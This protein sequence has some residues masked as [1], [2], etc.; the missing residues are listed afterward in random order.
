MAWRRVGQSRSGPTVTTMIPSILI[1]NVMVGWLDAGARSTAC[2]NAAISSCAAARRPSAESGAQTGT[3]S[4]VSAARS[5]HRSAS[6]QTSC[7][8]A[9]PFAS[10]ASV[11]LRSMSRTKTGSEPVTSGRCDGSRADTPNNSSITPVASRAGGSRFAWGRGL[12]NSQSLRHEYRV[13]P[14]KVDVAIRLV[15]RSEPLGGRFEKS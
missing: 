2:R 12:S 15:T 13:I 6:R 11:G 4:D 5:A 9:R 7:A 14:V 8:A 1:R 10:N 3:P